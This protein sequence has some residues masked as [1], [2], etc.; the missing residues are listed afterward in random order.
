MDQKRG[1]VSKISLFFLITITLIL[2]P[3]LFIFLT[4]IKSEHRINYLL[5]ETDYKVL[6]KACRELSL[7]A[8]SGNLK[9][10]TYWVRYNRYPR[11][12]D[13]KFPKVITDI[14]PVLVRIDNEG[15]VMLEMGGIPSYG[16]VAFPDVSNV[17]FSFFGDRELI[18]GLWYYDEDYEG[19]P[20]HQK[21]IDKLI[22]KGK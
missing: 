12:I 22:N 3:I 7:R 17:S 21:K 8:S 9:T 19:N 20:K 5:C 4:R 18:P 11:A 14:E 2:V 16:V 6:L 13:F 1:A 10:G 15:W